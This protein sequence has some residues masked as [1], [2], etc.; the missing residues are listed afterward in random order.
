MTCSFAAPKILLAGQR[1]YIKYF[2]PNVLSAYI[3]VHVHTTS[4][5]VS[6]TVTSVSRGASDL[7]FPSF[8]SNSPYEILWQ[9]SVRVAMR[10]YEAN[11][12]YQI[13]VFNR[14]Q[15]LATQRFTLLKAKG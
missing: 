1:D 10:G 2:P 6:F 3:L 8:L 7:V 11:G 9:H 13:E 5:L 14:E 12:L 15:Q 4:P